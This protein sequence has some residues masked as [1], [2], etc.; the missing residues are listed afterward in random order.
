MPTRGCCF[1]SRAPASWWW[2]ASASFPARMWRRVPACST[3]GPSGLTCWPPSRRCSQREWAGVNG[4]AVCC[5][6]YVAAARR[7]VMVS[8]LLREC[9]AAGAYRWSLCASRFLGPLWLAFLSHHCLASP[10]SPPPLPPCLSFMRFPGGCYVEGDWMRNAFRWKAALGPNEQRPGHMNGEG[11]AALRSMCGGAVGGPARRK[12]VCWV[13]RLAFLSKAAP[14]PSL[15]SC[16][17]A[18]ASFVSSLPAR[19]VGLLVH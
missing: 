9:V 6:L 10:V 2:T 13:G 16:L 15:P 11:P 8:R 17:P 4:V 19:R 5:V 12:T 3:L 7:H 14:P 1:T 18:A